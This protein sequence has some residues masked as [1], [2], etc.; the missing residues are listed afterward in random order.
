MI[1]S[2]KVKYIVHSASLLPFQVHMK[3]LA[4]AVKRQF[5]EK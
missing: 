3:D 4:E 1:E 5:D 2:C